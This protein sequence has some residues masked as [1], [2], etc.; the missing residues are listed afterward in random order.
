[1][2]FQTPHGSPQKKLC[3]DLSTIKTPLASLF[4]TSSN[5]SWSNNVVSSHHPLYVS[6]SEMLKE[7]LKEDSTLLK[8]KVQFT[9]DSA[10][11][12]ILEIDARRGT[13]PGWIKATTIETTQHQTID[14]IKNFHTIQHEG[15][16]AHAINFWQDPTNHTAL[17]SP[18]SLAYAKK[19]FADVLCS[20]MDNKARI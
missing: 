10:L 14:L 18:T 19:K 4:E 3:F 20:S 6:N 8:T 9:I 7:H 11:K 2:V 13:Y 15:Y 16:Q 5:T 1:M 17:M 12:V